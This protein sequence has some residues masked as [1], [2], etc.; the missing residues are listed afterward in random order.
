MTEACS[1]CGSDCPEHAP[2]PAARDS[3]AL[4]TW[5]QRLQES[6]TDLLRGLG[7]ARERDYVPISAEPVY[8]VRI[9]RL[10]RVEA[11]LR[12]RLAG[13]C[14]GCGETARATGGAGCR[15]SD[16]SA[17]VAQCWVNAGRPDLVE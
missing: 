10:A 5:E 15:C 1:V 3:V 8:E 2:P 11:D 6:G 13:Q 9:A 7:P 14:A 17:L 4:A 12:L 16:T